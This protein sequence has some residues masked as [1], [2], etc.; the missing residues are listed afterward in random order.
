MRAEHKVEMGD[1]HS[2]VSRGERGSVCLESYRESFHMQL[3]TAKAEAFPLGMRARS[4][5]REAGLKAPD[6]GYLGGPGPSARMPR[7]GGRRPCRESVPLR[8]REQGWT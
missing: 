1:P 2:K 3:P 4:T 8:L 5:A 6:S 7:R